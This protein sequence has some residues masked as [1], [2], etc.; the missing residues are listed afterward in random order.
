MVNLEEL[1][2]P[3]DDAVNLEEVVPPEVDAANLESSNRKS[4]PMPVNICLRSPPW[5]L[6]YV[7]FPFFRG[8]EP[9]PYRRPLRS[10]SPVG[11]G[12]IISLVSLQL[13]AG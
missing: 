8:V 12:G 4:L 2:P 6:M 3:E 1:V 11:R 7:I 10:Y 9:V 5:V 13:A